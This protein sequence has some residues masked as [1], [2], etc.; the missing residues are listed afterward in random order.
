M[1][2]RTGKNEC[3]M[4]QYRKI[5]STPCATK[6]FHHQRH[7][8]LVFADSGKVSSPGRPHGC[9]GRMPGLVGWLLRVINLYQ[10]Q[11]YTGLPSLRSVPG[12]WWMFHKS[13]LNH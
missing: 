7:I 11:N 9:N 12:M 6:Y 1:N 2:L 10:A 4:R 5:V 13:L 3:L 8:E